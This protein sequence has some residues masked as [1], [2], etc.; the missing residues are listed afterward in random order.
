MFRFLGIGIDLFSGVV[1][2]APVFVLLAVFCKKISAKRKL[3]FL[4][5]TAY[6][7]GVFSAT[8]IPTIYHLRLEPSF[9]WIPLIDI[10]NSPLSY[11]KNT[12]LNILLFFPLGFFLPLLWKKTLIFKNTVLFGFGLS[13]FIETAQIFTFRLTDIDDLIFNTVGTALGY[14]TARLLFAKKSGTA[15]KEKTHDIAEILILMS[16]PFAVMFFIPPFLAD[17]IWSVILS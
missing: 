1:L 16:L 11:I 9:N 5:F 4:L 10:I 13:V 2:T 14:F 15:S 17:F 8:G 12:L 3:L 7:F 6:M